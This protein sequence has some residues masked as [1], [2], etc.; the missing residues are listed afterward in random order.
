MFS[1]PPKRNIIP[2]YV[3]PSEKKRVK[4]RMDIRMKMLFSSAIVFPST[5]EA[6]AR[7]QVAN[8]NAKVVGKVTEVEIGDLNRQVIIN[9]KIL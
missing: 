7:K 6:L 5:A 4:V 9:S 2:D 1:K 8:K 3:I